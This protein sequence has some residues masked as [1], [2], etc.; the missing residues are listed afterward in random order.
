MLYTYPVF[1]SNNGDKIPANIRVVEPGT[2]SK[3]AERGSLYAVVDLRRH[4]GHPG[5]GRWHRAATPNGS[6]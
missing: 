1:L 3:Q 2:G 5:A 4:P 6:I